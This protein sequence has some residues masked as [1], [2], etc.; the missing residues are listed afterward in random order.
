MLEPRH[1]SVRLSA[2]QVES[3]PRRRLCHGSG[4]LAK[5]VI[6]NTHSQKSTKRD[7]RAARPSRGELSAFDS[8][9]V[10]IVRL[11]SRSCVFEVLAGHAVGYYLLLMCRCAF[12]FS[13]SPW[14]GNRLPFNAAR[15]RLVEHSSRFSRLAH[16]CFDDPLTQN[17]PRHPECHAPLPKLILKVKFAFPCLRRLRANAS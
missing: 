11:D 2:E 1:S 5:S 3:A 8:V 16:V 15:A 17:D 14:L 9:G 6:S 4:L 10:L 13:D 12:G 7:L